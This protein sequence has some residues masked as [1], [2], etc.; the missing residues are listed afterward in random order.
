MKRCA[1]L[2]AFVMI[3]K[4]SKDHE[5]KCRFNYDKIEKIARI[6]GNRTT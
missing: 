2:T 6:Q 5:E 1:V 3:A 4:I